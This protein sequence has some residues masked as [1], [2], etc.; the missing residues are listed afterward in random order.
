MVLLNLGFEVLIVKGVVIGKIVVMVNG[1][2]FGEVF[3]IVLVDVVCVGFFE[4]M[5]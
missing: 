5:C 4:C 2:L 3:V 1:K